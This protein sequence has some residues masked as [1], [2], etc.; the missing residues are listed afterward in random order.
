[1]RKLNKVISFLL[2][3]VFLFGLL[4]P[5]AVKANVITDT[6]KSAIETQCRSLQEAIANNS[7][8]GQYGLIRQIARLTEYHLYVK[9]TFTGPLGF[10]TLEQEYYLED[11]RLKLKEFNK[12][13]G[14][15]NKIKLKQNGSINELIS[16]NLLDNIPRYMK[17]IYR[18]IYSEYNKASS[19]ESKNEVL[20]TYK[21]VLKALY[22]C[23]TSYTK[24]VTTLNNQSI[25]SAGD[26][27]NFVI[28]SESDDAALNT[29]LNELMETYAVL[30][31][32]GKDAE[33]ELE[34]YL[35]ISV[36]TELALVE[37]LSDVTMGKEGLEIPNNSSLSA[38]YLALLAAS[39]VYTPFQSYA[40]SEEFLAAAANLCADITTSKDLV[41]V[42]NDSKN[43]RKPLYKRA[44]DDNG[45]PTGVAR[46]ITL[47]E[48]YKIIENGE[49]CAIVTIKGALK[50]DTTTNTWVYETVEYTAASEEGSLE[51][52][53]NEN[54]ETDSNNNNNGD[55]ND[56]NKEETPGI[57]SK[58]VRDKRFVTTSSTDTDS[59]ES[60]NDTDIDDGTAWSRM[61]SYATKRLELTSSELTGSYEAVYTTLMS[62]IAFALAQYEQDNSNLE[63]Q[64]VKDMTITSCSS[65]ISQNCQTDYS[66]VNIKACF[67]D[68]YNSLSE[69][70]NGEND[71]DTEDGS[72]ELDTDTVTSAVDNYTVTAVK[73]SI[74]AYDEIT[75]TSR[76]TDPILYLGTQQNRAVDNLTSALLFNI[77]QEVTNISAISDPETRFVYI[78]AYGDIVLDDNLVIMP[79]IANPLLYKNSDESVYY[80]PFTVAFMNSYPSVA[81]Q[82]ILTIASDSDIGKYMMQAANSKSSVYLDDIILCKTKSIHTISATNYSSLR[83][84]TAFYMNDGS[85]DTL[86]LV[87]RKVA[88]QPGDAITDTRLPLRLDTSNLVNGLSLFPYSVSTDTG[89]MIAKLIAGN[90][91]YHLMV[92]KASGEEVNQKFLNDNYI[93]NNILITGLDGTTNPEAYSNNAVLQYQQLQTTSFNRFKNLVYEVAASITSKLS[94]IDGVLGIKNAYNEEFSGYI[95]NVLNKNLIVV[96]IIITLFMVIS[97]VKNKYDFIHMS[98]VVLVAGALTYGF[99]VLVPVYIPYV[100]NLFSMNISDTLGYEIIAT[101]VEEESATYTTEPF[102]LTDSGNSKLNTTSLT[103]YKYGLDD[104]DNLCKQLNIETTDIT[105]GE[106]FILDENAG[107]FVEGD[108]LKINVD[109]LFNSLPVTGD[110][111]LENGSTYYEMKSYKTISNNVDYYVPY[112][113]IVDSFINKLNQCIQI[114]QIPRTTA[115]YAKG[116]QKDNFAVWSYVNS[117]LFLTP[118]HYSSVLDDQMELTYGVSQETIDLY[119]QQ[120]EELEVLLKEV[121]GSNEDWLGLSSFLWELT[122]TQK[123]TLWATTLQAN[124]YYDETW[125]VNEDKMA[126]LIYYVNYQTKKFII[127]M[128]DVIGDLSDDTLIKT[129]ALRALLAFN[130]RAT[131]ISQVLYPLFINYDELRLNDISLTILTGNYTKFIS[132]DMDICNY[133]LTEHGVFA[134]IL[135][136]IAIIMLYLFTYAMKA[137]LFILYTALAILMIIKFFFQRDINPLLK[138]YL[139]T[140]FALFLDYSILC[141]GINFTKKLNANIG[142]II[143]FLL[144]SLFAFWLWYLVITAV[145]S[146]FTELGNVAVSMKV[147]N[148]MNRFGGNKVA[149]TMSVITNSIINREKNVKIDSHEIESSFS[150]GDYDETVDSDSMYT[151]YYNDNINILNGQNNKFDASMSYGYEGDYDQNLNDL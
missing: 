48:F 22:I 94:S 19:E 14:T 35:G 70:G 47:K 13:F 121:F 59:E 135:Y 56:V 123:Q 95:L 54:A 145:I 128:E 100:F 32:Y 51:E 112:Y 77:K 115:T 42:Y 83:M 87:K 65:F 57:L 129:I 102:Q 80:N 104:I 27:E 97:F 24:T 55:A 79:G 141:I 133:I 50:L 33:E 67:N 37:N 73:T 40:G 41:S 17:K 127:D 62:V 38:A 151:G 58:R 103:L 101:K 99:I 122:S 26:F 149:Q 43:A 75:E 134:L 74:D 12:D 39:S 2:I 64:W 96:L 44:L 142:A 7:S 18:A 132:M 110:Y 25:N 72:E 120:S 61:L 86:T 137:S 29:K 15:S 108:C 30:Y 117:P 5:L 106:T 10:S 98:V 36:N 105:N 148:I 92:D 11:L 144:I 34:A 126:S 82:A 78:N 53:K 71:N 107:T 136:T 130:Q 88:L 109:I 63:V 21:S 147:Q 146:N 69:V 6:E 119:Y 81:N 89:Y 125:K 139:K 3:T 68:Y 20:K 91:Y 66:L 93:V 16:E 23:L 8:S 84:G 49:Q 28:S 138:G 140:M 45:D 118:G 85:F 143:V 46:I 113:Q 76:M 116:L 131:E 4:A 52:I 31:K 90:A 9:F 111:K 124:G 150:L 114:Y 60:E 1:M